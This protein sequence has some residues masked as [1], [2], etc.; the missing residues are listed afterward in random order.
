MIYHF[1]PIY[2]QNQLNE[3]TDLILFYT[4]PTILSTKPATIISLNLT[5]EKEDFRLNSLFT[6]FDHLFLK[7]YPIP[8][9]FHFVVIRK[10]LG[11]VLV[12][13]YRKN[14]LEA[15]LRKGIN[16]SFLTSF[17]FEYQKYF[18]LD[19]D[20]SRLKERFL[21]SCPHELGIFLGIPV[22]DVISFIENKG[23]NYLFNGYWKVYHHPVRAAQIFREYDQARYRML[24]IMYRLMVEKSSVLSTELE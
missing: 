18:D 9:D 7:G 11:T 8:P 23:K 1:T 12:L 17:G 5:H 21:G 22:S 19:K 6:H 13:F 10:T 20:L 4:A 14:L 3:I 24:N 16:R 2:P 15:V